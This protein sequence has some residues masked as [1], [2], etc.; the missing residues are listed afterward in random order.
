MVASGQLPP[1]ANVEQLALATMASLEG[2][3]LLA[4]TNRS[5]RPIEVALDAAI[6]YL[7]TFSAT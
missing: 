5:V 6:D 7:K 2:G 4:K 1:N 3:L